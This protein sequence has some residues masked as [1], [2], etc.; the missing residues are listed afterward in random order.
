MALCADIVAGWLGANV[1]VVSRELRKVISSWSSLPG[2][3]PE[4][5]HLDPWVRD[6]VLEG[7]SVPPLRTRLERMAWTV[8]TLDR[9]LGATARLRGW[10]TVTHEELAADPHGGMVALTSACGLPCDDQVHDFIDS[11]RTPGSGFEIHRSGEQ[12]RRYEER[13]PQ[14]DWAQVDEVL[15]HVKSPT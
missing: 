1:I 13:L 4:A 11:L 9:A 2:F 8:A 10:L 12:I 15:R 7:V 5:L 3:E 6:R 14:A